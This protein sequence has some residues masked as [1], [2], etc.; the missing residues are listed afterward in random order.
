ER[1]LT[2]G[3]NKFN[4]NVSYTYIKFAEFNGKNLDKLVSQ[5]ELAFVPETGTTEYFGLFSPYNDPDDNVPRQAGTRVMVDLDLEAQLFDFS[6]TYGVLDNLD[7]NIDI[8]VLRTYL[9]SSVQ[10]TIPDPRCVGI[11]N[12]GC[13]NA[14]F[15]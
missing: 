9:R 3:R 7:V 8:P 15:N 10:Q 11:G 14:L 1:A 12:A 2:L 5:T 6:F 13:D 4:I